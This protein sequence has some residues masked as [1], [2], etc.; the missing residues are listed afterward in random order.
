ME[1]N[2]EGRGWMKGEVEGDR[3]NVGGSMWKKQR[4]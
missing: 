1:G 4:G 3:V 2:R